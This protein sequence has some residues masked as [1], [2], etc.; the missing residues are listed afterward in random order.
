M[1][2]ALPGG[3]AY[4]DGGDATATAK[5]GLG[6]AGWAG[7]AGLALPVLSGLLRRR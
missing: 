4:A 1:P 5:S 3:P 7:V 6:M 2:P